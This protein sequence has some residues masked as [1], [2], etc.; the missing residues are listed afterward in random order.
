MTVWTIL[1]IAKE[2]KCEVS[3]D[4]TELFFCEKCPD[5]KLKSK[6]E[7][8]VIRDNMGKSK[9]ILTFQQI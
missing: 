1:C 8:K 7:K 4:G 3:K 9:E 5:V 2:V 6:S